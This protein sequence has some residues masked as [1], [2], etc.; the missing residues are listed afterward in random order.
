MDDAD[1]RS[2]WT[3]DFR[4]DAPGLAHLF[5][6]AAP[7][8]ENL[9][10]WDTPAETTLTLT[11]NTDDQMEDFADPAFAALGVVFHTP[12]YNG[13]AQAML[14]RTQLRRLRDWADFVLSLMPV[15]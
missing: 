13:K 11:H 4:L 15:P 5:H 8:R 9:I 6:D 3:A 12:G 14:D 2:R 7:A 10:D 1:L